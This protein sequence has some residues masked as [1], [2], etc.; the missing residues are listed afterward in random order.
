MKTVKRAVTLALAL[1]MLTALVSGCG[2]KTGVTFTAAVVGQ[3][4]T[5]DPA[6]ATDPAEQIAVVNLYENLMKLRTADNGTETVPAIARSYR[7]EDH[8]DGTQTYVFTLR[9]DARWSDGR[10]VRAADFV[11]AWQHLVD[12]AT[13]SPY[14]ELLSMVSGYEQARQGDLSALGVTAEGGTTLRVELSCRCSYF[15]RTVCTSP[16]TVPRR[17]D[18]ENSVADGTVGNG[19]Y[20]PGERESGE[21]TLT[22]SDRYYDARRLEVDTLRLLLCDT[23]EQAAALW[24]SGE[25]DFACRMTDDAFF[26]ESWTFEPYPRTTLLLVN[27]MAQQLESRSLRQALSLAIDR[28]ALAGLPGGGLHVPAEGLIPYGITVSDGS[29]FRLIEGACIDNS[30]YEAS[31]IAARELLGEI[32]MDPSAFGGLSILYAV[33]GINS[34]IAESIRDMW[35]EQLGITVELRGVSAQEMETALSQGEFSVALYS[36]TGE[37][38]DPTAFLDMWRSGSI[39]N[40]ALFHSSAYDILLRAAAASSSSVARDAYLADAEVLLMEQGNAIPLY[41][42]RG[43]MALR[44]GWTAPT[45]DGMGV[46]R[47]DTVRRSGN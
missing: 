42:T 9:S 32:G 16:A 30:D 25:A 12:P 24:D 46:Y 45:Y 4:T 23:T 14:A 20:R 29:A 6:L 27:Q 44:S 35:K 2:K 41:F 37:I 5:L 39:D 10:S 40:V 8:P 15:L 3:I 21:L 1:V 7:I 22:A 28:T 33:S 38:N 11:Y 36:W 43:G 26:S 13:A 47:F 31:C 17:A 18:L 19:A 34:D